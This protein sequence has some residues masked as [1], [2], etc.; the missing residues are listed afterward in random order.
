MYEHLF[1]GL[2]KGRKQLHPGPYNHRVKIPLPD[3]GLG[4]TLNQM[5]DFFAERNLKML[6]EKSNRREPGYLRSIVY[7]FPDEQT[8]REFIALFGGEYGEP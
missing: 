1:I 3:T 5:I 2:E 8:A 6:E 7:G 4:I